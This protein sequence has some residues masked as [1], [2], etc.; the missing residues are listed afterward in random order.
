[1]SANGINS[2]AFYYVL[3]RE[4]KIL[5]TKPQVT[6]ISIVLAD[7]HELLRDGFK[8]ML[9]KF[10]QVQL[11][12]EASNGKELLEIV[13]KYEPQVVITDIK[14]PLL[15]GIESVKLI[16]RD[17]PGIKILALTN[18]DEENLIIDMI[19]AGADGY[20]IKSASKKEILDAVFTILSGKIYYCTT[21]SQKLLN[22]FN[23]NPVG[24]AK[25]EKEIKFTKRELEVMKL[26]CRGLTNKEIGNELGISSR[27]VESHKESIQEKI[28][29]KSAVTIALFASRNGYI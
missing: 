23:E 28:G 10:K 9:K 13:K 14:M 22:H 18:Y 4:I 12:G 26:I 19:Q 17:Y 6:P 15:D 5:M 7:D 3:S 8:A 1:M 27:T 11:V 29:G 24:N 16:K 21:T 20:L 2:F 25:K